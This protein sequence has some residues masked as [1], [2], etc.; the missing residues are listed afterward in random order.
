MYRE[1]ENEL[2]IPVGTDERWRFA[3]AGTRWRDFSLPRPPA[4]QKR[5]G[6]KKPGCSVIAEMTGGCDG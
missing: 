6:K 5:S 3:G 1:H 2:R 4:S